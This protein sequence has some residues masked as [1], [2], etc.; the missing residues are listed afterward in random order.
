MDII[1]INALEKRAKSVIVEV[2]CFVSFI[3]VRKK[4]ERERK[5]YEFLTTKC[6]DFRTTEKL[7]IDSRDSFR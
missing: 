3:A 7:I 6:F 2:F 4:E 1:A 5:K